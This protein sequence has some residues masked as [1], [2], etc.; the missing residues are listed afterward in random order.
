MSELITPAGIGLVFPEYGLTITSEGSVSLKSF[1]EAPLGTVSVT[2]STFADFIAPINPA[3]PTVF[4]V[5]GG[6]G[7]D[8]IQGGGGDDTL[9]GDLGDDVIDGGIGND[10]PQGGEGNDLLTGSAG[11]DLLEGGTGNDTLDG[12][13]DNDALI[14]GE[15]NDLLIGGEGNDSLQGGSGRD[16]LI[17]GAGRDD[18]RFERGSLSGNG[19]NKRQLDVVA[20]FNPR[21]DTIE[22]DRRILGGKFRD[23]DYPNKLRKEDFRKTGRI[24]QLSGDDLKNKIIYETSS[25]IVYF[26][27]NEKNVRA[28]F[29]V[30]NIEIDGQSFDSPNNV[31]QNDFELFF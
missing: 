14:A 26:A 20:D 31:N 1:P 6:D 3:D 27:R 5:S 17:G 4:N 12:G 10:N 30:G 21:E 25:G 15:G 28:L 13:G 24:N 9:I 11:R 7:N 16:T 18:F 29:Q 8:T 19:R 2:G 22:L 23:Q